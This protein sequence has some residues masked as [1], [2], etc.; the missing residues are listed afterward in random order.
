MKTRVVAH[1]KG[2]VQGVSFRYF[3]REEAVRY[4]L[5]GYA[6]NLSGGDTVEVVAEGEEA[7]IVRLIEWM[8]RGP[9]HAMIENIKIEQKKYSGEFNGFEIR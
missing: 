3:C 8:K 6:K 4:G 1:V 7:D 2:L 9:D 5:S